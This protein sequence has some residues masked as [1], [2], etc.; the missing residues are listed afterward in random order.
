MIVHCPSNCE[1][2]EWPFLHSVVSTERIVK[3][4]GVRIR[5][6][7][8]FLVCRECSHIVSVKGCAH[9]CH[10]HAEDGLLATVDYPLDP[11]DCP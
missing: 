1:H 11:V 5:R 8:R 10:L 4:G 6:V 3:A 7:V 2:D 9:Y